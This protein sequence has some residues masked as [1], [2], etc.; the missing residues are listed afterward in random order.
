MVRQKSQY[1]KTLSVSRMN[2]TIE[3]LMIKKENPL[4]LIVTTSYVRLHMVI[5]TR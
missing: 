4:N 3:H 2:E 1:R 5:S